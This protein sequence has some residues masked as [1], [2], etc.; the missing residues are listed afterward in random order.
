MAKSGIERLNEL[1]KE[2]FK[3]IHCKA[4]RF[5]YSGEPSREGIGEHQGKQGDVLYEGMV[6]A[7]QQV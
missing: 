2:I 5:A 7:C 6:D 1:K 4:C 3:C